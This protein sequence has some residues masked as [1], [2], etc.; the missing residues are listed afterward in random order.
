MKK[1]SKIFL[2]LVSISLMCSFIGGC[3]RMSLFD[4]S[5]KKADTR[6]EQILDFIKNQDKDGLKKIFSKQALFTTDNFDDSL[7]TLFNYIQ[8]RVQSWE[9]TGTYGGKD[10]KN[11]NGTSNRK[12]QIDSTYIF[13]TD[14]QEY[15]VAIYEFT[16]D[17][18]NPDNVGVYSFCI[19]SSEDDQYSE[20]RYWGNGE[21]GINIR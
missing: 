4:D 8:G 2:I 16:I 11:V 21:A 18:A 14:E 6:F 9:K 12:K 10:E 13:T 19:I 17:T 1:R 3:G 7:D 5:D 15:R 20:S